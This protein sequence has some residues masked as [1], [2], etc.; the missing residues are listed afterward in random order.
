MAVAIAAEFVS[1]FG[2]ILARKS[3]CKK[4]NLSNIIISVLFGRNLPRWTRS[5]KSVIC[6]LVCN[7]YI[8]IDLLF[9][10]CAL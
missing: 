9:I 1:S 4:R 3:E 5:V 8:V 10:Y 6:Q 2:V 7:N